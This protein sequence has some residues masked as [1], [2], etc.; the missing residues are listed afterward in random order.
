VTDW[1]TARGALLTAPE[2]AWIVEQSA[3]VATRDKATIV[4][5][6]VEYGASVVC[7]HAGAPDARIVGVDLDVTKYAGPAVELVKGDAGLEWANFPARVHF[8][9]VDA[10]HTHDSVERDIEG[11][12]GKVQPGGLI[13]FHDYTSHWPHVAGVKEA[14]DAHFWAPTTWEPVD[15]PDSIKAFRRKGW[16]TKGQTFGTLGFGVPY[17]K[18]RYE[19]FRWWSWLL[20][21]GGFRE[22]DQLLNDR[23]MP[24]EVPIPVAHNK[25]VENFLD[26]DRD[27]LLIV[28]DDHTGTVD[29]IHRM[30]DKRENAWFDVVCA[31]YINRRHGDPSYPVGFDLT[32]N[33]TAYGEFE[34]RIE[35]A[36]VAREGTQEYDGAALGCV[37]IRRWILEAMRGDQ[38]SGD[39][40][41][42]DWNGRN[43]QDVVFYGRIR[44]MGV[45]VGVD[46][47]NP[48]GHL[49]ETEYTMAQFYDWRDQHLIKE[50]GG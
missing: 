24:G 49:G 3:A 8:L 29:T 34:C 30:R 45:R 37:L 35:R 16:L 26:T 7:S 20:A 17:Y 31:S 6:G 18:A 14:V 12:A 41:W 40:F 11:W 44:P 4:H 32:E 28:E 5:L 38:P 25:L 21:G 47:D 10:G 22:G 19:F 23:N 2:R 9:F 46:R 13:A 43:S 48:I 15:A 36:R 42:F 39:T 50:T 27:T 33:V 1:Q